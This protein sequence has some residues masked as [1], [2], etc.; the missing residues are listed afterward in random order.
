MQAALSVFE[1][2]VVCSEEGMTFLSNEI[3][4][5]SAQSATGEKTVIYQQATQQRSLP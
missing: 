3:K 2:A 1:L 4:K 5:Q